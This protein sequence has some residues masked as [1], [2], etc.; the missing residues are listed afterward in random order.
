MS[1]THLAATI[2]TPGASPLTVLSERVETRAPGPD[3]LLVRV[4]HACFTPFDVW[5]S[6]HNPLGMY[7]GKIILGEN[8]VGQ[9]E[10]VGEGVEGFE[11]GDT[12]RTFCLAGLKLDR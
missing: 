9:V 10:K 8:L 4:Q 5:A 6:V 2:P 12:V 3:E 7:K 11:V 1:S